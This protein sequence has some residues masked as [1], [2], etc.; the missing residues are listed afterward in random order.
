VSR[1]R[2]GER[3]IAAAAL[4]LLLLLC[5]NW[6]SLALALPVIVPGLHQSGWASLGWLVVVALI[7]VVLSVA[8]LVV[9]T[10]RGTLEQ[11]LRAG[12]A[13]AALSTLVAPVLIV[14][15]TLLQPG[16]GV[17]AVNDAVSVLLPGYLGVLAMLVL[18]TGA[19]WVLADER[20]DA[21]HSAYQPPQ[22][23]PVP[24]S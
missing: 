14:R 7:A 8:V 16:L 11:Q 5:L 20:T 6:F 12:V 9:T 3:I 15:V 2:T 13:T 17:G 4:A 19:W 22:P 23:R 24:P 18:V 21:P 1:L 10:L